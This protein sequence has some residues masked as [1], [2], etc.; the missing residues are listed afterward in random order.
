MYYCTVQHN[1]YMYNESK[2]MKRITNKIRLM[3][4]KNGI[5]ASTKG[6]KL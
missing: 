3:N 1:Q 6:C 4:D 2:T 5:G